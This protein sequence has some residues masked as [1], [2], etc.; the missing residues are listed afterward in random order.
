MSRVHTPP[1]SS[2]SAPQSTLQKGDR[3]RPK[4]ER[5]RRVRTYGTYQ[6]T[7]LYS[8]VYYSRRRPSQVRSGGKDEGRTK[9]REKTRGVEREEEALWHYHTRKEAID[10]YA[11]TLLYCTVY[12]TVV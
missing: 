5:K 9:E 2:H 8:T 1:E 6:S 11:L 4:L 10:Y 12:R 7:V 3:Q